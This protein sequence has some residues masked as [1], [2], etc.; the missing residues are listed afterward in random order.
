MKI[1]TLIST[2]LALA[3]SVSILAQSN[4]G[5]TLMKLGELE[6]AKQHF[7]KQMN[8]NP[9]EAQYYLGEV[10]WENGNVEEAKK[11]YAAAAAADAESLLGQIGVAKS[12]LKVNDKEAKKTLENIYKKNKKDIVVVLEVAKAFYDN[13]M[14]AEGDKAVEEAKKS[15]KSNPLIYILEGDRLLKAG[16]TGDAAMQYDQAIHFDGNNVLALIK[17]G[18]VYET[19]NPSIAIE[20]FKKAMEI[21]PSNT[22]VNR[23]L[24]KVYSSSGR[25]PQAIAIY[26]EYFLK[27]NYN[28]EDI[29]YFATSLYFNKNY[30]NAQEILEQ[31]LKR[32]DKNF[33]F[34]RLMMYSQKELKKYEEGL[35]TATKFFD[36]RAA[37][38]SG[39]IDLDY[40]NYGELL[41]KNGK[42]DEAL[43]A[44]KKAIELNP[45]NVNLFKDLASSMASNK[46][47]AEA[48]E[49][50]NHYIEA[51]GEDVDASDY[52]TL[53]RY[54][55]SAGQTLQ[56]DSLPE[57]QAQS[58][59]MYKKADAAFE[60]VT[61]RLPDNYLGYFMRGGANALLDPDMKQGL[62]RP[63]YEKTI[64][65]IKANDE[66]E[67]R[68]NIILT[69]FQYLAILNYYSYA[70]KNSD[71]EAKAKAIEYCEKYCELNPNNENINAILED[72][73]K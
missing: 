59:E 17:G 35:E 63:Y 13:G 60:V 32:D 55:Q 28:L 50:M 42:I 39:Y 29:R 44:Y 14:V 4:P 64:E 31:G 23:Y 54:Y 15:D 47:N 9:A 27:G 25:H 10:A 12:E 24:A 30:A 66:V 62:A 20:Q 69:A 57:A 38:D 41:S 33:V 67:Q 45:D 53:G 3:V 22:L 70:D 48:A 36:L 73:T 37:T 68:K 34:N 58:V 52:Y 8:N 43:V 6:L 56:Q 16:K 5:V 46:L 21:D 26:N 72:L 49:Y 40:V 2:F 7:T 65:I 11:H 18:K 1:K 61:E 51:V 71:A 19:I